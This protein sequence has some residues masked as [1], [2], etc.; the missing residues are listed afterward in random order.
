MNYLGIILADDVE[1]NSV[2]E[3]RAGAKRQCLQV[4]S[5]PERTTNIRQQCQE[6][7][8]QASTQHILTQGGCGTMQQPACGVNVAQKHKGTTTET[9]TLDL[10]RSRRMV[11]EETLQ[12]FEVVTSEGL[13][14]GLQKSMVPNGAED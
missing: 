12:G 4:W 6:P 9:L 5:T 2:R 13:T 14:V 3:F 11:T 7:G 10:L 8:A 1:T